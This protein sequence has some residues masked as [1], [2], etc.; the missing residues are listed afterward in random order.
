MDRFDP[1][2]LNGADDLLAAA[3]QILRAQLRGEKR[4][5]HKWRQKRV[6]DAIMEAR[7]LAICQGLN[8]EEVRAWRVR[9]AREELESSLAA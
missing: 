1:F 7:S 4:R 6:L 3:E 8:G 9:E 5:D 2:G